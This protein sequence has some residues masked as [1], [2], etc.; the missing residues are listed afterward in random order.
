MAIGWHC[1]RHLFEKGFHVNEILHCHEFSAHIRKASSHCSPSIY[2]ITLSRPSQTMRLSF[3]LAAVVALTAS[4]SV[5]GECPFFCRH[6]VECHECEFAK[7]CVS[8]GS[9]SGSVHMTHRHGRSS[10][11]AIAGDQEVRFDRQLM[12]RP[13][14]TWGLL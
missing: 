9:L 4:V 14:P 7:Q 1:R 6:S 2:L 12:T 8:M 10:L 13:C 3:A 11:Y 5:N